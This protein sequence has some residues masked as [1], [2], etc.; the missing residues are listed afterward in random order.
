MEGCSEGEM[1]GCTEGGMEGCSVGEGEMVARTLTKFMQEINADNRKKIVGNFMISGLTGMESKT[2]SR[3]LVIKILCGA[4]GEILNRQFVATHAGTH[5]GH[6][7]FPSF[8]RFI[9]A[10]RD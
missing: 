4:N 3:L 6:P 9:A 2:I 5:D 1:E 10:G 8:W 7:S